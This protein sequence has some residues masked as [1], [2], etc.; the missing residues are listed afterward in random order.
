ME[1]I[2]TRD[3]SLFPTATSF[4]QSAI[5]QYD[6]KCNINDIRNDLDILKQRIKKL[7]GERTEE[8]PFILG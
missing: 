3:K 6:P 8:K 1:I 7:E 4:V 2:E 5:Y